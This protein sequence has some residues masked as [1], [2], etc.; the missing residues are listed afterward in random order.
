[1]ALATGTYTPKP[2]GW[3]SDD[4]QVYHTGFCPRVRAIEYH[5]DGSLKRI[6]FWPQAFVE[7]EART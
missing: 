2:C 5:L 7:Q 1:M 4:H 3:C 6:E